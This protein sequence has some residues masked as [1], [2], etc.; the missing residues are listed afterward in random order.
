MHQLIQQ[1]NQKHLKKNIP[2]V[3]PGDTVKVHQ[4]ITEAGKERVQIFEG[5]VIAKR[6]KT[7]LNTSITVR[8]IAAGG[9]GV[10]KTFPIHSPMVVKIERLKSAKIR[11]AKLYYLRGLA[12]KA[13]R[14][15]ESRSYKVWE[16]PEAEKELEKIH[17]QQQAEAKVK[18]LEK[19]KEQEELENKFEQAKSHA[20]KPPPNS[21]QTR[22]DAGSPTPANPGNENP[23]K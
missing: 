23:Q 15:K 7:A 13:A 3:R 1:F 18:E 10:E 11:R 21:G 2:D 12:G 5:V 20:A 16:E 19:E 14:L 22:G 4:K 17:G 8:K 9:I 6:G